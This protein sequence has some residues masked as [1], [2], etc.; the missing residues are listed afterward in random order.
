MYIIIKRVIYLMRSKGEKCD[1]Y[2]LVYF[3]VT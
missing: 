2:T 1:E 3:T